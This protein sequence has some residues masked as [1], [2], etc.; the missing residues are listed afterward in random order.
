MYSIIAVKPIQFYIC[1]AYNQTG[2]HVYGILTDISHVQSI[3]RHDLTCVWSIIRHDLICVW[4]LNRHDFICIW[5]TNADMISHVYGLQK[6]RNDFTS[7]RHDFTSAWPK[8]ADL[9]HVYGLKCRH[10]FIFVWFKIRLDYISVCSINTNM[11]SNVNN[12]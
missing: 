10:D 1:M 11:I 4:S 8:N 7:C 6:C 3:I 12:L 2:S 5:S 9:I